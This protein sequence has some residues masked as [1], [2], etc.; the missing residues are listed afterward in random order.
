MLPGAKSLY[1]AR[2]L[3]AAADWMPNRVTKS[4][5][6]ISPMKRTRNSTNASRSRCG[7]VRSASC[8]FDI[9]A[10]SFGLANAY[11]GYCGKY[12]ICPRIC[13]LLYFDLFV[14]RIV[15][16]TSGVAIKGS[17][18]A[19]CRISQSFTSSQRRWRD[20]L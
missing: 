2:S 19:P 10:G 13:P 6:R 17:V 12:M 5:R 1:G 14:H 3:D 8:S 4:W 20:L 7:W 9:L 18:R 16:T 11:T 15:I